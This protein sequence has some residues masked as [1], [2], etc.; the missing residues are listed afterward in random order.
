M[1]YNVISVSNALTYKSA[2]LKLNTDLVY[3]R[4][5]QSVDIPIQ[6]YKLDEMRHHDHEV[7]YANKPACA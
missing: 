2:V 4:Y 1:S 6:D 3:Y 7:V 5:N